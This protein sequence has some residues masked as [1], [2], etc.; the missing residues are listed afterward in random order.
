[1][2]RES[3][4][5]ASPTRLPTD[6]QRPSWLAPAR[7]W[8]RGGPLSATRPSGHA[9]VGHATIGRRAA[10]TAN[11]GSSGDHRIRN[12]VRRPFVRAAT[13]GAFFPRIEI[14]SIRLRSP[15]VAQLGNIRVGHGRETVRAGSGAPSK[16]EVEESSRPPSRSLPLTGGVADEGRARPVPPYHRMRPPWSIARRDRRSPPRRAGNRRSA[17]FSLVLP[18]PR[19]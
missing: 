10:T 2:R 5:P 13:P 15:N 9:T 6:A 18:A 3:R 4:G 11:R 14:G 19:A 17:A 7:E 8:D 12:A 1:M 16:S